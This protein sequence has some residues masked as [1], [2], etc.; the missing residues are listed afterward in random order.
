MSPSVACGITG[1]LPGTS[2]QDPS[3]LQ[4]EVNVI[5]LSAIQVKLTI[6]PTAVAP[7]KVLRV[8]IGPVGPHEEH[9]ITVY[10]NLSGYRQYHLI[11]ANLVL[12][13]FHS[14]MTTVHLHHI[15]MRMS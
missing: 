9:A 4:C 6:A 14:D 1:Q 8:S 2:D 11:E 13:K 15:W 3:A 5:V 12:D 7:S 10:V